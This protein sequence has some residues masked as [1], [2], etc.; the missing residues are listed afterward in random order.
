MLANC[1]ESCLKVVKAT[2][3][4]MGQ[5][6]PAPVRAVGTVRRLK[7]LQAL[8]FPVWSPPLQSLWCLTTY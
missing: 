2:L 6:V 1:N 3:Q 7:L 8:T 5:R 4:R